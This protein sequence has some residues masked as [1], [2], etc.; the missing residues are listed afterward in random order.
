MPDG[1]RAIA[2]STQATRSSSVI[3]GMISISRD[4]VQPLNLAK[5]QTRVSVP[6]HPADDHNFA[7]YKRIDVAQ[8]LLSVLVMLAR[9]KMK[10]YARDSR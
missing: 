2:A 7:K 5:A 4:Q 3:V 1:N 6:H 10:N 8:T 9:L